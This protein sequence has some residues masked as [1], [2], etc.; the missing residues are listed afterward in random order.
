MEGAGGGGVVI[1]D[2]Y[3][4]CREYIR[5]KFGE[6]FTYLCELRDESI[7]IFKNLVVAWLLVHKRYPVETYDI[8]PLVYERLDRDG[9][10][11]EYHDLVLGYTHEPDPEDP[12]F[13]K[14]VDLKEV[15]SRGR[16]IKI[17]PAKPGT[18]YVTCFVNVD[19]DECIGFAIGAMYKPSREEILSALREK[20]YEWLTSFEAEVFIKK[21]KAKRSG[22]GV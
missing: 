22:G 5:H 12:C 21:L 13:L 14:V 20:Y 1:I 3:E 10:R 15:L 2:N 9:G 11:G 6:E 17:I 19:E 8:Y 7:T 16:I 4:K 18:F